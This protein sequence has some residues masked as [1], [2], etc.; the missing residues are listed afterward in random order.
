MLAEC[1]AISAVM[2]Q[3]LFHRQFFDAVTGRWLWPKP[4]SAQ[5]STN[6]DNEAPNNLSFSHVD[7]PILLI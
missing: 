7:T 3:R 4:I 2:L 5:G 6:D 1:L